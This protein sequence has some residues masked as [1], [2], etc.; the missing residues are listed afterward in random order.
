MGWNNYTYPSCIEIQK[1]SY[2][3]I[4]CLVHLNASRMSMRLTLTIIEA[5]AGLHW[6]TGYSVTTFQKY[7]AGLVE[8][9]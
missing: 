6:T 3:L 9:T 7:L 1:N 5:V 2:Y 8:P 4:T